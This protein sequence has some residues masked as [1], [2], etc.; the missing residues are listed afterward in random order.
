MEILGQFYMLWD[1]F[2]TIYTPT[3]DIWEFLV[4]HQHW[5]LSEFKIYAN[6]VQV[7]LNLYVFSGKWSWALCYLFYIFISHFCIYCPISWLF[8]SFVQFSTGICLSYWFVR[9][10]CILRKLAFFIHVAN[11]SSQLIVC[12]LPCLWYINT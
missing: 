11:I 10:L 2:L 5:V 12:L 6:L 8:V 9:V 4:L 7:V 3:N 1:V